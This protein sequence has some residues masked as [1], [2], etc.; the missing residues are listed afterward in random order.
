[1]IDFVFPNGNEEQLILMA[2][3]LGYDSLC[4]VYDLDVDIT[5]YKNNKIK[6][7]YGIIHN[8]KTKYK[9]KPDFVIAQSSE[10]DRALIEQRK[11][12]MIFGFEEHGK[13]DKM[14][15]RSSGLN[16]VLAQLMHDKGIAYGINFNTILKSSPSAR[17]QLDGRIMQNIKLMRKYKL[18]TVLA[19]LAASPFE[20][21]SPHDLASFAVSLGM[22]PKE[23]KDALNLA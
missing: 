21:R 14:H 19:S 22:H 4:F 2:I 11:A 15:Q 7:Y 13:K 20:M 23:A 18:K 9:I 17:S 8:S 1:M 5:K 16:Q 3:K 10:T 12:N 6:L